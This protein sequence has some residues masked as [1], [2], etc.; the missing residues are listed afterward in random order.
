MK[1]AWK[2]LLSFLLLTTVLMGLGIALCIGFGALLARWLPLSLFQA[3]SL[4]IGATLAVAALIHVLSAIF[5]SPPVYDL[6]D[7]FEN[8]EDD[9]DPNDPKNDTFSPKP[10]FSNVGRNDYCPCGSGRKFKNCCENAP[11]R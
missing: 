3:S 6:D 9:S 1:P 2:A 4:A 5:H 10:D 11:V 7:D 8:G